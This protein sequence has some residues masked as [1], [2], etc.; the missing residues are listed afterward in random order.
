MARESVT[1]NLQDQGDDERGRTEG[2]DEGRR[3]TPE[4]L[5][6]GV[7]EARNDAA[8]EV[9]AATLLRAEVSL[10]CYIL[11]LGSKTTSSTSD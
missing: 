10:L 6:I 5:R 4:R 3:G 7:C 11:L 2:T 8:Q 1:R 9:I